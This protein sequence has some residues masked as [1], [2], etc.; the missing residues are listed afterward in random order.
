MKFFTVI[1]V[2]I[3]E[4]VRVN[5]KTKFKFTT[6]L[7]WS[8]LD[9]N[10]NIFSVL[11]KCLLHICC[12]CI[13]LL[14]LFLKFW[15]IIVGEFQN[16]DLCLL[17]VFVDFAYDVTS[18]IVFNVLWSVTWYWFRFCFQLILSTIQYSY[19]WSNISAKSCFCL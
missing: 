2:N 8:H 6:S 5:H 10:D 17:L 12:S 13:L 15:N 3:F 11:G 1:T 4:F 14:N 19:V 9:D 7:K 18:R 16:H